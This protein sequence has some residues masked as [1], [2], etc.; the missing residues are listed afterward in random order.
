MAGL[1]LAL[2]AQYTRRLDEAELLGDCV[3]L[4]VA[5]ALAAP[6]EL[7]L[8]LPLLLEPALALGLTVALP[9]VLALALDVGGRITTRLASRGGACCAIAVPSST[10]SSHHARAQRALSSPVSPS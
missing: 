1:P 10:P 7:A 4:A 8:P 3:P 6:L 5:H 9:L 2:S